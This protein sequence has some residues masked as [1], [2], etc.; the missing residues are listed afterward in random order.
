MKKGIISRDKCPVCDSTSSK[1]IFNRGFKEELIKG[2]MNVAYQGNADIDFLEDVAFEIVK[3]SECNLSYQKHVLDE[4]KLNELYNKW[5][6]PKLALEWNKNK[7][8]IKTRQ[9]HQFILDTAKK[10]LEK[11][12]AKIK[13]LDYGAGFGDILVLANEM[14]FDSYAFEYSTERISYLEGKG[15]K[16][17][18]DED[19]ILFDFIIVN[20]VFEHLTYPKDVIK[21]ITSKL[22]KNGIVYLSVPNC[23]QIENKLKKTNNITDAKELHK[24][25]LDASV[26]AFQHINFFNKKNLKFFVM[27]N[28]LTPIIPFKYALVKPLS[29]KSF[30]KPYYNYYF[31]TSYFLRRNK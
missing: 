6:D 4:E 3:C 26:G 7:R 16:T 29:I 21:I 22:N 2:Y 13:I 27:K 15:I 19:E 11:D 24:V 17:I 8:N 14:G 12:I 1:I 23:P 28:K 25:L 9:F 18:D 20:Q 31:A 30:I 5:I 10:L